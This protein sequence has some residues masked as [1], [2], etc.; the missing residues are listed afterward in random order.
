MWTTGW[1][2]LK[3]LPA[4]FLNK[5]CPFNKTLLLLPVIA[6]VTLMKWVHCVL[7]NFFNG[8]RDDRKEIY[9]PE[10]R[11]LPPYFA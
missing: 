11:Y 1:S 9:S 10:S 2:F 4:I 5:P 7:V 8:L 6:A 3:L